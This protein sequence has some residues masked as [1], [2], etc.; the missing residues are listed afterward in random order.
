MGAVDYLT[1]SGTDLKTLLE[2]DSELSGYASTPY[3]ETDELVRIQKKYP[4][5]SLELH[6][7]KNGEFTTGNPEKIIEYRIRSYTEYT[8]ESTSKISD[9]KS[10]LVALETI[11]NEVKLSMKAEVSVWKLMVELRDKL[12]AIEAKITPPVPPAWECPV[13]MSRPKDCVIKPCSHLVC[14]SCVSGL[15]KCPL[16]RVVIE[17]WEKVYV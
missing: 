2:S 9:I 12:E 5:I 13:C 6:T 14:D 7:I 1:Q 10:S 11:S 15:S 17:R 3:S 4:E 8:D 16:C